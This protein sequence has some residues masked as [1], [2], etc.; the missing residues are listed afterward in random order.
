[1][2]PSVD[3]D[4]VTRRA[5]RYWLEDGLVEIMF[6][7]MT[8]VPLGMFWAASAIPRGPFLDFVSLGGIQALWLALTL[9]SLW[10]F[11][12]LKKRVTF[13]RTGYVALPQPTTKSRIFMWA[14]FGA[15]LVVFTM[16]TSAQL[17]RLAIPA[18]AVIFGLALIGQ[19]LQVRVPRM[20]WEGMLTLLIGAFL[21]GFTDLKGSKGVMAL[22]VMMGVSMAIIGALRLRSFVKANPRHQETEA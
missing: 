22:L 6:G 18:S 19:G 1:M 8:S 11:K 20:A 15:F 7:L 4:G 16:L 13:P 9:S 3:V 5:Q 10:G 2:E 21:Y 12:K 14:T 17:D